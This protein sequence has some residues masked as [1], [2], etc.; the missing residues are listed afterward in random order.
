MSARSIQW[1]LALA[2]AVGAVG[3]TGNIIGVGSTTPSGG[4]GAGAGGPTCAVSRNDEVRLA[5]QGACVACH[6][7]GTKPFFASLEAFENGLVWNPK[8]VTPGDP[9]SSYLVALLE[10]KGTGTY[11]QMP[12][13]VTY[14]AQVDAHVA[15]ISLAEIKTW[16]KELPAAPTSA[17]P[18]AAAFT[19]RRLTAEEMIFGLMSQLDLSLADFAMNPDTS[20][21]S[22]DLS[23]SYDHL[24][25]W[26][27]DWAPGI[28]NYY[29]SDSRAGERFLALGGPN[30]NFQ[31]KR[32]STLAP[33]A[34][35]TLVQVS[36]A[37]CNV[38]LQKRSK[39]LLRYVTLTDTS[40]TN[41]SAIK[42]NIGQLYLR[43]LAEPPTEADVD[44]LYDDL[45]VPLETSKDT[46]TAWTGVC[47]ALVRN[48]LWLTY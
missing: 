36:Q 22:G 23:F 26:P 39:N 45:Y 24:A 29:G 48:P 15:T 35:G 42:K 27:V 18:S 8:Y 13:G 16:L 30:T 2:L 38:A 4:T 47:A 9:D 3:C 19:V 43:M 25:V 10:G 5:M 32:D 31:R 28:R 41:P 11:P 6:A 21:N 40:K 1:G 44:H 37:W 46:S 34:V 17:E 7:A 33:A 14:T 20:G 12:Q